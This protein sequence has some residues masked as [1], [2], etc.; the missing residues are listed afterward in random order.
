MTPQLTV[1]LLKIESNL[2]ALLVLADRVFKECDQVI[3][4]YKTEIDR[5]KQEAKSC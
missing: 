3:A 2:G 1:A 4:D 5:L